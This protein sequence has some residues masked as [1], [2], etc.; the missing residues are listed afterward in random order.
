LSES[1]EIS[2]E[3]GVEISHALSVYSCGF[4]SLVGIDFLVC[5]S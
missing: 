4:S 1:F 3:I 2:F 5:Y